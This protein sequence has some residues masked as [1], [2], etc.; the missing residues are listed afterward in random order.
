MSHSYKGNIKPTKTIKSGCGI[1]YDPDD[2]GE[3]AGFDFS[4]E[5]KLNNEEPSEDAPTNKDESL[6]KP[7]SDSSNNTNT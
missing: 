2:L 3:D 6:H 1:R 7:S 4:D 5:I